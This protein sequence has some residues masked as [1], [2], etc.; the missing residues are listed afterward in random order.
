MDTMGQIRTFLAGVALW[1]LC[2]STGTPPLIAFRVVDPVRE[3]ITMHWKD[4]RGERFGNLG[5]LKDHLHDRALQMIFGM[6]GGMFT[7]DHGP[8][9]LY[10]EDGRILHPMDR[11]TDGA[12]N[13]HMQPNGVFGV[14]EDGTAFVKTTEAMKDMRG[15]RYATQSGPMLIANGVIN[16]HFT[17]GSRNLHIRN[18]VGVRADGRTVFAISRRPIS[19]HELATWF[20]AHGCANAL[21][22]DG[23]V[24][25]AFIP[26]AGLQDMDG[27]LGVLIAVAAGW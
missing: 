5:R 26:E 6:N 17:P 19:F 14:M 2:S 27:D 4:G 25:Q 12:G 22:L 11:R 1:I 15:V 13:F 3:P 16:R 20:E 8:V 9:G 10:I 21:Y 7:T 23:A 18:G 24:S